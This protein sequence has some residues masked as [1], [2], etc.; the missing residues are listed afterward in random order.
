MRAMAVRRRLVALTF[1]AALLLSTG[2]SAAAVDVSFAGVGWG[3]GVGL[4]QYGAKA[5]GADGASY[6][7]I[8]HRYFT[9][10]AIVP[11]ATAVP[12]MFV[13][14]D[15]TPFWV[16]LL[17]NSSVVSFTVESGQARLC[18]DPTDACVRTAQPGENFRFGPD[19]SGSCVF[20][21]LAPTGESSGVGLP[22]SC[23]ASVR[24]LS[25]QTILAVPY[26]ARSYRHGILRFR[27]SPMTGNIHT[28]YEIGVDNYMRG[29]S[30]VPDS[31]STAAIEAQV[32]V[33]RS[34]AVW[35][36][37]DRG[38]ENTFS[39]DRRNDCACNL[40]DDTS[41]QVFRGWTGESSHPNWVSAVSST[42]QKVMVSN[43]TIVLGLYSSSSG[44]STENYTDVFVGGTHPYLTTVFDSPVFADSAANPHTSWGA[45]YDQRALAG[46]FGFSWVSN[47]EVVERNDSGSARTVRLV[48]IVDGQRA[49]TTVT[50]VEMRGALSLRSTTFEIIVTPRFE[51]V[52]VDA[53]FAGEILGLHD[54]GITSG[55]SPS[56]YCP[57]RTVTRAEM[58]AF[59]VRA[60]GLSAAEGVNSFVDV[61]GHALEA[62]ISALQASGITGGCT[63]TQ[64]CPERAV[65]RAEMAAFLVRGFGSASAEAIPFVDTDGHFFE[66]EI[67]TLRAKGITGGCT[68]TQFCPERAVT[69]AEMAAFLIRAL[70]S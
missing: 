3:H 25:D 12:D 39:L 18:F 61:D 13:T 1:S 14:T 29:L 34:F 19:G 41:D 67:S 70:A 10:V 69:R 23:D 28:V 43:G 26:K 65:T 37:L 68:P 51:D 62:E 31:W 59:L 53:L 20:L 35:N 27:E 52:P 21:H 58:A 63:P 57:E 66:A 15:P 38:G 55:C 60:L 40:R 45:G 33:S 24:P 56:G 32:V 4:S 2:G 54:L 64:F 7:Q 49:E 46:A 50:G 30:E 16:G 44:G 9:G 8:L 36:A 6:D 48:G 22:G 47:V 11:I 5:M 42:A 17:Q